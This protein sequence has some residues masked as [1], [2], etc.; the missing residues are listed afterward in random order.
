LPTTP[1]AAA[2]AVDLHA[3]AHR[4]EQLLEQLQSSAGAVLWSQIEELVRALT[5]LY[6]AGL[7][8]TVDLAEQWA[9]QEGTG[10]PGGFLARL[11]G[12]ELVASLLVLHDAHPDSLAVRAKRAVAAAP[13]NGGELH[14]VGVEPETGI[15]RVSVSAGSSGCGFDP[16]AV[17]DDVG[18]SLWAALPDASSIE[19]DVTVEP[20]P[21]ATPVRLSR[22]KAPAGAGP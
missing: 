8:R 13:S 9:D 14:L 17:V 18:Q 4:I 1:K 12:D 10:E 7:T 22:K 21:V 15:V 3:V 16:A 20:S 19:V 11:A 2:D 5:D 6:G